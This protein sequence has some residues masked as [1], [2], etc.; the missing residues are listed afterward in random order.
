MRRINRILAITIVALSVTGIMISMGVVYSY[1][2]VNSSNNVIKNNNV[3]NYQDNNTIYE[4]KEEKKAVVSNTKIVDNVKYIAKRE[5]V[6]ATTNVNIRKE[7][8]ATSEQIGVL[9][10]GK[11]IVRVATGSNGWDKVEYNN[12]VA[13]INHNYLSFEKVAEEVVVVEVKPVK[14]NVSTNS[15]PDNYLVKNVPF[16]AQNPKYPNGCEAASTVMLLNY[17][18]MKISLTDFINNYLKMD[19]V[20]TKDGVRY[21]PNPEICY[22][23]D[24]ASLHGG[25]GCFS[26]AIENASNKLI[27]EKYNGKYTVKK[28]TTNASLPEL[29]KS[30][31]PV[32]IWTTITYDVVK[33]N[34]TWKS[35]DGKTTYSYPKDQ[36]AVV[37]IGQD[38]NYYYVNDPLKSNGNTK[39]K[40][41]TLEKSFDSMGRKAIM[42]D[43][44]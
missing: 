37:V 17:Y 18:G 23:G 26:T 44:K 7:S 14:Q 21:G 35:Y 4:K 8:N 5:T 12:G 41:S 3:T 16:V 15:N 43:Y 6:Y 25:W 32:V 10:K 38:D 31:K 9:K 28:N 22:A 29:A 24:P 40:K 19:K 13:Y 34:Y 2:T 1:A 42:I 33:G 30:K 39:I 20:Y 11:S 36:H 27:N